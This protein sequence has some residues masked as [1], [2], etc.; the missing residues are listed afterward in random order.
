MSILDHP[1]EVDL[2][3][4][5]P[6][7]RLPQTSLEPI[8]SRFR[9]VGTVRG[10]TLFCD[11]LD[12]WH[13]LYLTWVTVPADRRIVL[14]RLYAAIVEADDPAGYWIRG[15]LPAVM[16]MTLTGAIGTAEAKPARGAPAAKWFYTGALSSAA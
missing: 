13:Q 2:W 7:S 4:A 15:V 5:P 6:S 16:F 8:G 14:H 10:R 1:A 3:L 9:H 12:R 11:D